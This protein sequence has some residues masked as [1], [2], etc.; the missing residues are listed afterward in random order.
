MQPN[1]APLVTLGGASRRPTLRLKTPG[2]TSTG[3]T[4]PLAALTCTPRH[5]RPWHTCPGGQCQ[6]VCVRCKCRGRYAVAPCP[7][8]RGTRAG[9]CTRPLGEH[10]DCRGGTLR[11]A[12]FQAFCIAWSWFPQSGVTWSHPKYPGRGI[13]PIVG[14]LLGYSRG[15][16]KKFE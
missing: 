8:M 16:L 7:A 10:Q 14:W 12:R 13:T 11:S 5:L 9:V 2:L 15:F 1:I 3:M 6:G 4:L